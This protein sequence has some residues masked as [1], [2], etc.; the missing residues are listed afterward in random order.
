M[1]WS[2]IV[3]NLAASVTGHIAKECG[4]D[5]KTQ[6]QVKAWTTGVVGGTTAILTLDP[7]G[8]VMVAYKTKKLAE[9]KS[10]KI[11]PALTGLGVVTRIAMGDIDFDPD[12]LG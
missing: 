3:G 6:N 5:K 4:A 2:S 7:I 11:Y 10:A 1:A 12:A 8:G 9:G